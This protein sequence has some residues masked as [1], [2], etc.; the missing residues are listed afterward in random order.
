MR[1][2]ETQNAYSRARK[3]LPYGVTSN[4]RYW[5]DER[6]LV[7][8]GGEGAYLFDLDGNKYI[9]YRLG[10][11]PVILG[12]GYKPVVQRVSDAISKGTIFAMTHEWEIRVAERIV[13]MVPNVDEVRFANSGTEATM[14]AIRVARAVTGRDKVIKFEGH[15]HGMYDYML[16]ST[17]GI[18][19]DQAG[20][21]TNPVPVPQ[22]PGIPVGIGELVLTVPW[23]NF[24]VLEK[25]VRKYSGE[26]A[27]IIFEPLM[28]NAA[29]IGPQPGWLEF[30]RKMCDE[31]G[32]VMIM[33]EVKTG[34]RIAPGGAQ[35]F[36]GIR[37]DIVTFAKAMGNGFPIAAIA[38][39]KE[40]MDQIGPGKTLQGGTFTGNVVGTAAADKVLEILEDG[41]VLIEVNQKGERLSKGI[42]KILDQYGIPHHINGPGSMFGLVL[43]E[44]DP[45]VD[46]RGWLKTKQELY[47]K[48]AMELIK[49]GVMPDPDGREPWFLCYSLTDKDV[50]ETLTKFEESLKAVL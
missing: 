47:T 27:A 17:A 37:S 10:F 28:G 24:D 14:H 39:K 8:A 48:L 30:I 20:A 18:K 44:N 16:Y 42:K 38:G 45:P 40:I 35:E 32:I 23:N 34:F 33:D 2:N 13:K 5:G 9:D 4:F 7:T 1:L 36:F 21:E 6:T 22:T 43:T 25:V 19:V 12:H 50:D 15:Y 3:I 11:G 29:S 26:I 49:R 41:T 46:I 31:Y